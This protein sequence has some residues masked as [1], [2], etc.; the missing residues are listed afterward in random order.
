V[1]GELQPDGRTRANYG[2][3]YFMFVEWDAAGNLRTESIHQYGAAST[4]TASPHYAD[5]APLFA[6]EEMKPV[7]MDEATI[8][9]NLARAYRPGDFTGPWYARP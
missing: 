7:W 2:D 4:D 6:R 3:G 9:E 5:Q 1:R 8:R